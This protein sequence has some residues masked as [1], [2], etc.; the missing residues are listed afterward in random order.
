M[1]S[2]VDMNGL[3]VSVEAEPRDT[4]HATVGFAE[5][6]GGL[7]D[8]DEQPSDAQSLG[9]AIV[10]SESPMPGNLEPLRALGASTM[11]SGPPK[12]EGNLISATPESVPISVS[13]VADS[14][15]TGIVPD[16]R[17]LPEPGKAMPGVLPF[18]NSHE[19]GAPQTLS[20]A[21]PTAG[22]NNGAPPP[23]DL[24]VS[25]GELAGHVES[26]DIVA[27]GLAAPRAQVGVAVSR[28]TS[29][30]TE[31]VSAQS[32]ASAQ[33]Q[34]IDAA[35]GSGV[36]RQGFVAT[37]PEIARLP[38]ASQGQEAIASSAF[39]KQF[40]AS[41]SSADSGPSGPL[42]VSG[43]TKD[44]TDQSSV[45]F[46]AMTTQPGAGPRGSIQALV[47]NG[48]IDPKP[49]VRAILSS[50]FEQGPATNSDSMAPDAGGS[51]LGSVSATAPTTARSG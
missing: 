48:E 6:M 30:A 22:G 3:E 20:T 33:P 31:G 28:P 51:F 45:D 38:S 2:K 8:V 13:T 47:A 5:I 4:D 34:Y 26:D 35:A 42:S 46:E 10:D 37:D 25:P 40:A 29:T 44:L 19:S 21:G 7:S 36:L 14:L 11:P 23:V 12:A 43:A 17:A 41:A 24:S 49:G 16:G 18:Q 1:P 39:R 15:T 9:E 27:E 50:N 32:S